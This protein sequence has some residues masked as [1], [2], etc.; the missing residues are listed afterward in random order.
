M[1][2]KTFELRTHLRDLS[3]LKIQQF[4]ACCFLFMNNKD[5]SY[6]FCESTALTL[7]KFGV[8]ILSIFFP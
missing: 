7:L 8:M 4:P 6:S 2:K 5:K 1:V 3:R